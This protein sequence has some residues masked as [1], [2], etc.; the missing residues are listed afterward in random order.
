MKSSV[1]WPTDLIKHRIDM[2]TVLKTTSS[3]QMSVHGLKIK[4]FKVSCT[5]CRWVEDRLFRQ[6]SFLFLYSTPFDIDGLVLAWNWDQIACSSHL[7]TGLTSSVWGIYIHTHAMVIWQTWRKHPSEN[8][9]HLKATL[10]LWKASTAL[11]IIV[12]RLQT[13]HR[14]TTEPQNKIISP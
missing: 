10:V 4:L 8:I 2:D 7:S 11:K 3:S 1:H 13:C 9:L 5:L 6:H 14:P 12:C